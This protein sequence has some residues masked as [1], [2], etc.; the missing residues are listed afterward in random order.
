LTHCA[1]RASSILKKQIRWTPS[2]LF[3]GR[4]SEI[5]PRS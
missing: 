4:F 3:A 1:P 2:R 5:K